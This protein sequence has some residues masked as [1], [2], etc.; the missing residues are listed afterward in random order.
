MQFT[1]S[2]IHAKKEQSQFIEFPKLSIPINTGNA[3]HYF[4]FINIH[5]HGQYIILF[6]SMFIV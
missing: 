6:I 3:F 4:Y 5:I 1:L 2:S